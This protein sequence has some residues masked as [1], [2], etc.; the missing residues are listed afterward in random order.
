[1]HWGFPGLSYTRVTVINHRTW[2]VIINV[3]LRLNRVEDSTLDVQSKSIV[4][5]HLGAPGDDRVGWVVRQ[6]TLSCRAVI[7]DPTDKVVNGNDGPAGQSNQY[8]EPLYVQSY[9]A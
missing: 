7:I 3:R 5:V 2:N 6:A 1:M 4:A 8:F 9:N